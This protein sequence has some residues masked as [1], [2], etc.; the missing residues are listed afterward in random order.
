MSGAFT[1]TRFD[2]AQFNPKMMH[3]I[4]QSD[5]GRKLLEN[6]QAQAVADRERFNCYANAQLTELDELLQ[7]FK[8]A[9]EGGSA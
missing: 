9:L 6:M 4:A 5:D 8:T 7:R 1:V 3:H 2:R